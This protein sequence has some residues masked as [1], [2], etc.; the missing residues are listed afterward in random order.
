MIINAVNEGVKDGDVKRVRQS[1]AMTAYM[2]N[3]KAHEDFRDSV[4]FAEKEISDLYETDNGEA[5]VREVSSDNYIAIAKM[6]TKNFSK[7]KTDTIL[8][9]GEKLFE[10]KVKVSSRPYDEDQDFFERKSS[11]G[12][13]SQIVDT[14]M[15][16]V[17]RIPKIVWIVIVVG[18]IIIALAKMLSH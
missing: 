2:A 4:S 14:V 17:K 1:L 11:Q 8:E 13:L 5:I 12:I 3:E 16:V 7:K 15:T 9:I 18:L 6:L 10:K